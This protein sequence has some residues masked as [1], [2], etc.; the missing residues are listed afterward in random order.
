MPNHVHPSYPKAIAATTNVNFSIGAADAVFVTP[1]A[2][3]VVLTTLDG[4]TLNFGDN[5]DTGVLIPV[6]C[7][8]A[9]F[10]DAGTVWALKSY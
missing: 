5:G 7:T 4:G 8:K 2:R 9:T 3:A 10:T 1:N 6:A